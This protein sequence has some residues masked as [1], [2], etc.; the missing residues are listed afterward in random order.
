M[1]AR[2]TALL[3][4]L[5]EKLRIIYPTIAFGLGQKDLARQDSG[6]PRI[7]WVPTVTRHLPAEKRNT[8]PRQ[9]LT[10]AATV[11]AHCWAYDLSS[12]S[13]PKRHF[14]ACEDLV[15][16]LLV[17]LHKSTWGSIEMGGEEWL[18]PEQ[19]SHGH[20]ALVTFSVKSPVEAMT[21]Q[22]VQLTKLEPNTVG[23]V[24]GDTNVDWSEP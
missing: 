4:E 5:E 19:V 17:T 11:V 12:P 8:N 2:V 6:P 14:D 20:A 10:R 9:L 21:Y 7:V 3:D 22:T 15:A 23:S 1:A 16:N 13:D 24:A 18:Q